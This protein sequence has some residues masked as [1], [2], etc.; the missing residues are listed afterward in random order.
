M[1]TRFNPKASVVV[2]PFTWVVISEVE[3]MQ[4]AQAW[5]VKR[6]CSIVPAGDSFTKTAISSPQDGL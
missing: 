3:A 5:P 4:M 6:I 1:N 2:L